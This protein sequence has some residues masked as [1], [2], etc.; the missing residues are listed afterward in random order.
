MTLI[1]SWTNRGTGFVHGS[2]R[3]TA[4]NCVEIT[5]Q[6]AHASISGSS[7]ICTL[8]TGY[9]PSAEVPG[10]AYVN[11]GTATVPLNLEP[12]GN[13]TAFAL[14]TGTTSMAFTC[15]YPLGVS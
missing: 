3:L 15:R 7:S 4:D 13:V 9:I 8:P 10:I 6:I 1:N 11:G 14:P 5:G 12:T 2:Y